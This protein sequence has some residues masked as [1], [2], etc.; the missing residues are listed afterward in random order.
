MATMT[1]TIPDDKATRV[2]NAL[3]AA[4]DYNPDT[5]GP[6]A[7]FAKTMVIRW[8]K[9][10]VLSVESAEHERDLRAAMPAPVPIDDLS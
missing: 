4:G 8:M 9:N 7:A 5:D 10:M 1:I 6:K 2:I 3:C